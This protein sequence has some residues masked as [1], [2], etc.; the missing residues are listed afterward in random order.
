MLREVTLFGYWRSS[1]SWRVRAALL[2]KEIPFT[3][4]PVSLIDEGGRQH[5]PAFAAQNPMRQVPLL[6]F[7]DADGQRHALAQS[8]AIIEFLEERYPAP[9]PPLL[10]LEPVAR[11]RARQLAEIINAGTQP[12]QNLSVLKHLR[13]ELG[14]DANAWSQRYIRRGLEAFEAVASQRPGRFS[15]GDY[16]TIADLC[17]VPQLYNARRFKVQIEDLARVLAV[18]AACAMLPAFIAAR[19]EAQPDAPAQAL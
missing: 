2:L 17:L 14:Q 11:A 19:P 10:P 13:E 9:A 1:A 3:L 8:L 15:V 18:E 6:T 4:E 16:P 12:L 5:D 7:T